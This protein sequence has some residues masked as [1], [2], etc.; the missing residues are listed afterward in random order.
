MFIELEAKYVSVKITHEYFIIPITCFIG[1]SN[2]I[3]N[4]LKN[5]SAMT[6]ML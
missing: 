3:R 4:V 6:I 5:V 1:F 2:V